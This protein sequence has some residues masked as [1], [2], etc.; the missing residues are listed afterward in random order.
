MTHKSNP[1]ILIFKT[2]NA[3]GLEHLL[4]S[5]KR[6]I[7]GMANRKRRV[8]EWKEFVRPEHTTIYFMGRKGR[9]AVFAPILSFNFMQTYVIH[10]NTYQIH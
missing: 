6:M 2:L 1:R 7:L 5:F 3:F 10:L 4:L 9:H 8:R